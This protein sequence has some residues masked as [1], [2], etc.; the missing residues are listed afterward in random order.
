MVRSYGNKWFLGSYRVFTSLIPSFNELNC[1]NIETY[2]ARTVCTYG[3]WMELYGKV[4][5]FGFSLSPA[6][7]LASLCIQQTLQTILIHGG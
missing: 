6:H 1:N 5:L 7:E 2:R 4:F 3:C